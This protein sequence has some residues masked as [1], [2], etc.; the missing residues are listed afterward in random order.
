MLRLPKIS[1]S[2]IVIDSSVSNV[3]CLPYRLASLLI[4]IPKCTCVCVFVH[5]LF[6]NG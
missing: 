3:F 6:K 1:G 5:V 4:I 2:S